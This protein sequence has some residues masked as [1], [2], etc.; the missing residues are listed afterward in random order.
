MYIK[1]SLRRSNNASEVV[2]SVPNGDDARNIGEAICSFLRL[3][4]HEVELNCCDED[5]AD[6]PSLALK[7]LRVKHSLTQ[8]EFAVKLGVQQNVISDM[9]RGARVIS[10]KMAKKIEKIF[11]APYHKFL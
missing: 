8:G 5:G 1:L 2:A 3:S 9:E 6:C 4:G 11:G 10:V 7:C